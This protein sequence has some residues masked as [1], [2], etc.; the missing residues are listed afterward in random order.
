[1]NQQKIDRGHMKLKAILLTASTIFALGLFNT[2]SFAQSESEEADSTGFERAQEFRKER[3]E[4]RQ[5]KRQ[6]KRL[7]RVDTNDDGQIDLTEYLTHAEQR[8]NKIDANADGYITSEEQTEAHKN[9]RAEFKQR[10]EERRAK[11][12]EQAQDSE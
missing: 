1:M 3:F 5:Q 2:Q 4:K 7:E 6:Q 10:R 8:F 11:R 9:M 12:Q